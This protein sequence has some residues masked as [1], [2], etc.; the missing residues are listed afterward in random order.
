MNN[1]VVE[2]RD[3]NKYGFWELLTDFRF[4]IAMMGLILLIL[5][6]CSK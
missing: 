5:E 1:L 3:K 6:R 4:I 2:K